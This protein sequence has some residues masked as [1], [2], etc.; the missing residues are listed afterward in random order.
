MLVDT[1][2]QTEVGGI[3][4]APFPYVTKPIPEFACIPFFGQE[5]IIAS[6]DD[7]ENEDLNISFNIPYNHSNPT[8]T[9]PSDCNSSQSELG[10]LLFKGSWPGIA[11]TILND[12]KRYT[13]YFKKN[14]YI[15]GDEALQQNGLICIRGRA[16]DV[17]NVAGHRLSTAEIESASCSNIFVNECAVVGIKDEISGQAIVLFAVNKDKSASDS[18]TSSSTESIDK[19]CILYDNNDEH[20]LLELKK[21]AHS[22]RTTLRDRIGPIVNPK[23]VYLINELPK[24]RT[25]KIM[26]RVL[27]KLL[28]NEDVGDLSTCANMEC[29]EDIR[30]IINNNMQQ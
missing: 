1:Y 28:M 29:I 2:W 18:N 16:D 12:K 23:R 5:P 21:L 14:F 24:T 3:L 11:R 20:T 22:I 4:I 17:L 7:L 30:K 10:A 13:Q 27:R 25:G 15:T 19:K 8:N 26:R 9:T 6:I